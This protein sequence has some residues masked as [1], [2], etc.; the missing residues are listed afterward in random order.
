MASFNLYLSNSLRHTETC[1]HIH[2]DLKR[3]MIT[4]RPIYS[5]LK[6]PKAGECDNRLAIDSFQTIDIVMVH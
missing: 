2:E 4:L 6:C 5:V 3:V 1:S